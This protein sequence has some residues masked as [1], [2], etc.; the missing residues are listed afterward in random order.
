MSSMYAQYLRERTT[1]EILETDTGFATYRYIPD[2]K[3]VYIIDIFVLPEF[4]TMGYAAEIANRI[5]MIAKE[6][7]C[8]KMLG[9]VQPTAKGSDIS[10]KVLI[11]YG[12]KLKSAG[13]D[14]I[15]F[16]K[17]LD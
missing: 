1:D 8:K 13:P 14:W 12:M 3:A 10:M 17:N 11:G 4:R 6:Q 9:S 15:I 5:A 2:Q 16:E 7:G